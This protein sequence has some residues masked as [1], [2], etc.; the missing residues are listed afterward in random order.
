MS[1][2]NITAAPKHTR[3]EV[4]TVVERNGKAFWSKLG[5]GYLNADKWI[6]VFLDALPT[7]GKLQIRAEM[8]LDARVK[9]EAVVLDDK[10]S[11]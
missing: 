7:N 6:N 3:F 1:D 8:P 9:L 2:Q 4:F 10:V 5:R 11:E